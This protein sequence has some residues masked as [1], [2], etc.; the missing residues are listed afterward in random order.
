TT[1]T[2]VDNPAT[3]PTPGF[4]DVELRPATSL[5]LPSPSLMLKALQISGEDLDLSEIRIAV[6]DLELKAT[7]DTAMD[8]PGPFVVRLISGGVKVDE[9]VP[10]FGTAQVPVGSYAQLDLSLEKLPPDQI[11]PEALN[12]PVA[13][14]FLPDNSIV[15]E[16]TFLESPDNDIDQSGGQ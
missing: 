11:P 14:Q 7:G 15:I 6:K 12:D 3:R 4:T 5:T 2:A 13:R 8:F 10:P 9:A 1:T 16:G